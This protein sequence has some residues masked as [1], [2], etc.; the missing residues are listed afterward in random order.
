MA[1]VKVE[2]LSKEVLDK[3]RLLGLVRFAVINVFFGTWVECSVSLSY[4]NS[5]VASYER[6]FFV[7]WGRISNTGVITKWIESGEDK[8]VASFVSM[9]RS[10]EDSIIYLSLNFSFT[11]D[12]R[13]DICPDMVDGAKSVIV[14]H[15][16]VTKDISENF[17]NAPFVIIEEVCVKECYI[18]LLTT[19]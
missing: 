13:C 5:V 19:V 3:G 17:L 10:F 2:V 16:F 14:E 7:R 11:W 1:T 12:I 6:Y 18:Y 15:K 8:V 4:L 9:A